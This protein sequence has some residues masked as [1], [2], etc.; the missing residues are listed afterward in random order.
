MIERIR[1]SPGDNYSYVLYDE[2]GGTACLIDP[3]A[4]SG[5]R[6]CIDSES[7]TPQFLVNTHGHGDHTSGNSTFL[8][9]VDEL[10]C[11]PN[12]KT[13]I[14]NVTGT[15]SDGD[16]L[17]IGALTVE[18]LHTPGHT[19]GS[20]CLKTSDAII[21]G[22]AVFLAGC[23]NPKF[24]GSTRDL[25][26]SFRDKLVPLD[27][28]LTLYPGHDYAEKNLRFAHEIEPDNDYATRK[29]NDVR[30]GDEPISTIGEEKNYNPFFRFRESALKKQLSRVDPKTPDHEVFEILRSKRNKW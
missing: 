19:S 29:L 16:S 25:F 5:V 6:E 24:G 28:E 30:S 2:P 9:E 14:N 11:H 12:E 10:L 13:S 20:I 3:V 7:L 15:V 17:N 22:D 26:E 21:T 4:T 8:P 27:D 18:I 1:S 23:G